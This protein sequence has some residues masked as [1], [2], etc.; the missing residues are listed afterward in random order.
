MLHR[1]EHFD[2][3]GGSGGGEQVADVAFHG[4]DHAALLA[5]GRRFPQL[6]EAVEFH[7]IAD[8]GSGAVAF[9]EVDVVGGPAGLLI[10]GTHGAQLAGGIWLHQV[11][12][13]VVGEA[14]AGDDGVDVVVVAEGVF[15][16]FERDDAGAFA[17]DQAVGLRVKRS[18]A[19]GG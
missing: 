13:D 15:E 4:T 12:G 5:C 6:C 18:A 16:A 11:A 1:Q 2:Q 7:G 17:D 3:A 8:G 10:G 19:A 14:D 9:D